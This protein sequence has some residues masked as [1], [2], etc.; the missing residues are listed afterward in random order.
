MTNDFSFKGMGLGNEEAKHIAT[1]MRVSIPVVPWQSPPPPQ[2]ATLH[3]LYVGCRVSM[4]RLGKV[5]E[6]TISL[7]NT[8]LNRFEILKQD[9]TKREITLLL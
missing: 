4:C 9:H 6:N 1:G 7:G 3:T 8:Y 2:A 5:T